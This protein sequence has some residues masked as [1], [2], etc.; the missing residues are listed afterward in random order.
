[1]RKDD[2]TQVSRS[3]Y[4]RCRD[5]SEVVLV[6]IEGGGHTWPGSAPRGRF[7]GVATANVSASD[8]MWEFFARH[9]MPEPKRVGGDPARP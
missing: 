1:V 7:L 3:A 5:G 2:G 8:V 4:R 6:T 9:P